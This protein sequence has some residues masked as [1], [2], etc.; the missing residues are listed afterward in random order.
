MIQKLGLSAKN[1][2]T[3]LSHK[4]ERQENKVHK[5]ENQNTAHLENSE[6]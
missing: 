1:E 2:K 3:Y 5:T 6:S 4:K